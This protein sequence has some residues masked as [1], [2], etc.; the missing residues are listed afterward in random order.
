[1]DQD[2][3][4][5]IYTEKTYNI[6]ISNCLIY[7]N[8]AHNIFFVD[9]HDCVVEGCTIYDGHHTCIDIQQ[10]SSGTSS[11]FIIRYNRIYN[12]S[13]ATKHDN[14][15]Y[16]EGYN[17]S[18]NVNNIDI[19]Y[20]VLYDYSTGIESN[21][22]HFE[23]YVS[24][25]NI[26]NNTMVNLSYYCIY[27]SNGNGTV[28]VKNNIGRNKGGSS[29]EILRIY[30][31]SNK[32]FS[33]ND[34]FW[35]SGVFAEIG[36]GSKQY[37]TLSSYK[38]G[39]GLDGTGTFS[40]NPL[41]TSEVSYDYSIQSSSPCVGKGTNVGL[42]ID[43]LGNPVTGTPSVGAFEVQQAIPKLN[44]KVLLQ[45]PYSNSSMSNDLNTKGL[46][47]LSQPYNISP[48]SYNGTEQVS[49]IPS[50]V[51]DWILI[52]LRNNTQSQSL[53]SINSATSGQYYVVVMHRNHLA[54]MSAGSVS[55]SE[56]PSL[57][58]FSI[59]A[60]QSYGSDAMVDL[61]NGKWGMYAGDSDENGTI[62]VLDYSSVGS[63]IFATDYTRSDLDMN[64]VVNVL[65]YQK[66]Y[67]SIFKFSKVP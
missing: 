59:G 49:N 50:N 52:E 9:S 41:F 64:G 65:D 3:D 26:F 35:D 28:T 25:I 22:I 10:L 60:S 6:N 56:S 48:W 11:N 33:N 34:W 23:P 24:N 13:N 38:S 19:Y 20:N 62:N 57:Y 36:T 32:T 47:P 31:T 66:T 21:G 14:L 44:I 18:Q 46:I 63:N 54:I 55:V 58:D 8:G 27:L 5:G 42:N 39:T 17:S 16:A 37:S 12:S 40:S 67:N 45:G 61:G 2:T 30:D 15:I 29:H 1:M 53:L 4:D 7:E 43:F 51:V